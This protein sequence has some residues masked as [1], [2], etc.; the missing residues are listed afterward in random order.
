MITFGNFFWERSDQKHF[1]KEENQRA[2]KLAPHN[3]G[4]CGFCGEF[5]GKNY[6]GTFGYAGYCCLFCLNNGRRDEC[7]QVIQK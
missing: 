6:V 5:Y 1:S 7:V 2:L 3:Y 4:E